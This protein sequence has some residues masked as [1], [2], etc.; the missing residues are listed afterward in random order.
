MPS[1][2]GE[3]F[4]LSGVLGLANEGWTG[5]LPSY[6]AIG[7]QMFLSVDFNMVGCI[8]PT[9]ICCDDNVIE[10]PVPIGAP[11]YLVVLKV[12]RIKTTN[13]RSFGSDLRVLS[14]SLQSR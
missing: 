6:M 9:I 13:G 11:M 2:K 4:G 3:G 7:W 12:P 1:I 8:Y 5:L 10:V 14:L